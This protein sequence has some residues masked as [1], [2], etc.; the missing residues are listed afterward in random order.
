MLYLFSVVFLLD[1]L[2]SG[3]IKGILKC[4]YAI[5]MPYLR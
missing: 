5:A 1:K 3:Q 4:R 2:I